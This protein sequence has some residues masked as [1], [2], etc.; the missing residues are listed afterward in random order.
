MFRQFVRSDKAKG[1]EIIDIN[2]K[3][4]QNTPYIHN[5]ALQDA[6]LTARLELKSQL[7][8]V[9][10]E[11]LNLAAID[12]VQTDE[13]RREVAALVSQVL[14]EQNRPMRAQEFKDLI[15]ELLNEVLGFG[16]LEPL[17]ADP[18]VNDILVNSHKSVYVERFGRLERTNV[19]FRD[20]RHLLRI[21]DKIVSRVGRRVDESTPWVDARLEDGSRV[22]AIIRPC[23]IDGPSVSI[24]KFARNPLTIPRMVEMGTLSQQAADLLR[25]LVEARLNV[26]ISGGTG[27]GKTTMLN[28]MSSYIGKSERVV[29]IEDAAE[30]QLQQDHVVRLETRPANPSGN[31]S[32]TQRDLVRNALRM[33]PDRIIVGEV[34]GAETFDMLQAMNTGH[35]G[36]MTTIH[37]NTARDALG[38]VEQMVTMIGLDFPVSAIRSQIAAGINV[39]VQLNRLSDG[40]RRVMSISEITGME[41]NTVT[42]QD[43]FIFRKSGMAEDG[44]VLGQFMPTGIRPRCMDQLLQAGVK[45][46]AE[47]FMGEAP[48]K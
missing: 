47:M 16:P 46:G 25:G 37:A 7:H 23:A 3:A 41:G 31:G 24:R 10:L 6:E 22:N 40:S 4:V 28:A 45:F 2:S 36:S 43:I 44:T 14:S 17:L 33:R 35:D 48:S 13:L 34:R 26:L 5:E 32:V 38:R 1:A 9:L 30:L 11:R 20:E 42:M 39:V 12:K 8:D 19:R 29:T 15:D 21:I 27:S 18:T